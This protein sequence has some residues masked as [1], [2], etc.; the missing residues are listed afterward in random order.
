LNFFERF[1]KNTEISNFRKIRPVGTEL[2][3]ANGRADRQTNR[4]WLIVTF[5]NIVNTANSLTHAYFG[6]DIV[7]IPEQLKHAASH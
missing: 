3:H 5:C 6:G 1:L 7:P 2:F 4:T